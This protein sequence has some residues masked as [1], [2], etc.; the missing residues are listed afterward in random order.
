VE[1]GGEVSGSGDGIGVSKKYVDGKNQSSGTIPKKVVA[2]VPGVSEMG[3]PRVGDSGIPDP[4]DP[5]WHNFFLALSKVFLS[6][7][8]PPV[9][10]DQNEDAVHEAVDLLR[11]DLPEKDSEMNVQIENEKIENEK[12]KN[13]HVEKIDNENDVDEPGEKKVIKVY[14]R[15]NPVS[16]KVQVSGSKSDEDEEDEDD[17]DEEEEM[18]GVEEYDDGEK[19]DAKHDE[20]ED[21]EV[22]KLFLDRKIQEVPPEE[23]F[24]FRRTTLANGD[25]VFVSRFNESFRCDVCSKKSKNLKE[26]KDPHEDYCPQSKYYKGLVED[27]GKRVRAKG[28][29]SLDDYISQKYSGNFPQVFCNDKLAPAGRRGRENV[30]NSND[31]TVDEKVEDTKPRAKILKKNAGRK[32]ENVE[33]KKKGKKRMNCRLLLRWQQQRRQLL[34]WRPMKKIRFLLHH[35]R[36]IVMMDW[37]VMRESLTRIVPEKQVHHIIPGNMLLGLL[38]LLVVVKTHLVRNVLIPREKK[39][40]RIGFRRVKVEVEIVIL[41]GQEDWNCV[42]LPSLL[43]AFLEFIILLQVIV[44][45]KVL[46]ERTKKRKLRIVLRKLQ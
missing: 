31:S 22:S 3:M 32:Q 43:I 41:V 36:M 35:I 11:V 37:V 14:R 7:M 23:Y 40:M 26:S 29:S 16:K 2:S 34:Y 9:N 15:Y 38:L 19:E 46:L 12:N 8:A 44:Y 18:E 10:Q 4:N 5:K 33:I 6:Q 1:G 13:L 20:G 25:V 17:A 28:Y 30:R 21:D 39:T 45:L 24:T 27:L 42:L